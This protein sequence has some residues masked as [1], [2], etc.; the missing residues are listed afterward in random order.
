[1]NSRNKEQ[2]EEAFGLLAPS[3]RLHHAFVIA[4][5]RSGHNRPVGPAVP[6]KQLATARSE[7]T[8]VERRRIIDSSRPGESGWIAIKIECQRIF[9]LA[10]F[11]VQQIFSVL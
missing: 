9:V 4:D 8:Q 11:F 6:Q 2:P 3:D 5:G 7:G 10:N 1:M